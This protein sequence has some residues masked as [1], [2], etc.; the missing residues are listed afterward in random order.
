M[1]VEMDG[2][3]RIPG[4]L[5]KRWNWADLICLWYEEEAGLIKLEYL[6]GWR[7]VTGGCVLG[8]NM[9][10]SGVDVLTWRSLWDIQQR[11]V[12]GSQ[13]YGSE[14]QVRE[15]CAVEI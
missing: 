15:V 1:T 8:R 4:R 12:V 2:N 10:S 7:C 11:C 14:V 6:D 13:T 3:E 5:E 9:G